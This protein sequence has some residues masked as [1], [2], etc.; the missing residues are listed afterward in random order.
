MVNISTGRAM[1]LNEFLE[2]S[3]LRRMPRILSPAIVGSMI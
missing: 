3:P 1:K 2:K